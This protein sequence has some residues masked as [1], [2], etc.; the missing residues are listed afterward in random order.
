[1]STIIDIAEKDPDRPALI[2]GN[3]EAQESY[4][5]LELRSRRVAHALRALGLEEG[6]GISVL[7]NND[8]EFFDL[9]WGAL[10]TGLYFTPINWHLAT[11]EVAYIVENSDSKVFIA[12]SQFSKLT[13]ETTADTHP[14]VRRF[15]LHG[16]IDGFSSFNDVLADAP[17]D[18]P[19]EN[20]REGATMLYSSGT[21]GF[22]KGVRSPLTGRD[23]SDPAGAG[24][25]LGFSSFF[26]LKEGD[27]YLCPAPLY[28]AAPLMFTS[29]QH[30]IGATGVVMRQFDATSALPWWRS[31]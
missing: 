26:G 19:L 1:M 15:S 21:T 12:S 14:G 24:L 9:F 31:W 22:P 16:A 5:E 27:R 8:D 3:G 13:G 7:L 10:R 17:E 18:A 25:A 4:G 2:F 20:Q 30:R 29:M 11:A 23:F 6:D 28:H